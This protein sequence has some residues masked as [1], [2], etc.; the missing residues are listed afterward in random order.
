MTN[1][2]K[3]LKMMIANLILGRGKLKDKKIPPC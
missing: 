2:F 1:R 3:G